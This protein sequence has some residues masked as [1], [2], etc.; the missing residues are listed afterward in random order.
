MTDKKTSDTKNKKSAVEATSGPSATITLSPDTGKTK[1]EILSKDSAIQASTTGESSKVKSKKTS[2]KP[3]P[4]KSIKKENMQPSS[5]N[6][7]KISKTALLSILIAFIALGGVGGLYFWQNQQQALQA[8]NFLKQLKQQQ[9]DSSQQAKANI[10]Q[11]ERLLAKQ[12]SDLILKLEQTLSDNQLASENK[13]TALENTIT[14]LSQNQPSDWLLHEAEYLIRIAAR[15]IWLEQDTGAA[16]NLLKDADQRISELNSPEFLPIRQL[17]HQDIEAL[18]LMPIL[19]T[20]E[21]ILTLMAMEKQIKSL[22]LSMVQ[23]PESTE[24]DENFELTDNTSDWRSNLAKTWRKFLADFITVNRRTANVEPL[25]SPQYQQNLREN[26]AL[27]IQLALWAAS[28]QNSKLF[29]T[30]IDDIQLWLVEYFDMDNL[31]NQ[32]FS[33]GLLALNT[34]VISYDYNNKLFSLDAIRTLINE[35]PA[36][37]APPQIKEELKQPKQKAP[38][39]NNGTKEAI[40]VNE[41]KLSENA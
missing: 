23:I 40:V 9:T 25:M 28:K 15:T 29:S 8:Q 4:S 36:N 19:A 5:P 31:V 35:T 6:S 18:Q 41:N 16:I 38:K 10:E 14:R 24:S 22:S 12:K 13:I 11:V 32:R 27:K 39:N 1:G 17:I 3:T 33:T 30:A 20:E 26:L 7:T 37:K 21:V 2:P 34:K